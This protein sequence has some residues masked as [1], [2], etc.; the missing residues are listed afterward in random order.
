M[1]VARTRVW[2]G[3]VA[4]L[5]GLFGCTQATI[6]PADEPVVPA[7]R[8]RAVDP[9]SDGEESWNWQ[10]PE[11]QPLGVREPRL[12][13]TIGPVGELDRQEPMVRSYQDWSSDLSVVEVHA[14]G[15][16]GFAMFAAYVYPGLDAIDLP[17]GQRVVLGEGVFDHFWVETVGCAGPVDG[18]WDWDEQPETAVMSVTDFDEDG[19]RELG[20]EATFGAAQAGSGGVGTVVARFELPSD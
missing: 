2:I 11:P 16:G 15:D 18:D 9:R 5:A 19:A 20:F 8:E 7:E 12:A 10:E 1:G 13:G 3:L 6:S 17:L 14:Q 4:S